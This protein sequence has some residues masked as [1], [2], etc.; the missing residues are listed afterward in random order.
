MTLLQF[1]KLCGLPLKKADFVGYSY[2]SIHNMITENAKAGLDA[3]QIT[4]SQFNNL[5]D[6]RERILDSIRF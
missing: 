6:W 2:Q 3:K 5:I 4:K 1:K